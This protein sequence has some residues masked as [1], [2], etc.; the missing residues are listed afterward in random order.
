MRQFLEQIMTIPELA[1]LL[2]RVEEGGC[3]AS[4]RCSGPVWARR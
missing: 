4:S 2:R 3:P 1:E